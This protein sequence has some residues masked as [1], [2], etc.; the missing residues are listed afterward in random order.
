M[1]LLLLIICCIHW[2][3]PLVWI[4]IPVYSHLCEYIADE[5][6]VQDLSLEEKKK[7]IQLM[8]ELSSE[9]KNLSTIWQSSFSNAKESMKWRIHLILKKRTNTKLHKIIH[10]VMIGSAII[11]SA[12]TTLAY[13]P[14]ETF[15]DH[16]AGTGKGSYIETEISL[17]GDDISYDIDDF[18]QSE[19]LIIWDDGT[20][21][22]VKGD[23]PSPNINCAHDYVK[24]TV[25]NHE[26]HRDGGCTVYCYSADICKKCNCNQDAVFVYSTDF[27][28]CVH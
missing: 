24:G 21:I 14:L 9:N 28:Q 12:S 3:N 4:V 18:S 20:T 10:I 5:Y 25:K 7:Y 1:K 26:S 16:F 27:P 6:A 17:D 2:Y 11:L 22:P 13:K 15:E 23:I 8:L 19:T